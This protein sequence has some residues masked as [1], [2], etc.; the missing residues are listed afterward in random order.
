[1]MKIIKNMVILACLSLSFFTACDSYEREGVT[2]EIYVNKQELTLVVG[3]TD[4]LIVSPSEGGAE[5]E[6]A[7]TDIVTV[8]GNGV[9]TAV[10]PGSTSVMVK[11]GNATFTV[12]VTVLNSNI[13]SDVTL[14]AD[15]LLGNYSVSLIPG[16]TRK[17][18]VSTTPGNANNVAKDD[19][20]W[21]SDNDHV[22]HVYNDGTILGVGE[23]TTAVHYRLGAITKD[24]DVYVSSTS[25]FK[26]PH[27]LS[28]AVPLEL[29]FLD[30]DFGGPEVAWHDADANNRGGSSYRPDNGDSDAGGVDIE[31]STNIGYTANGEWL[32]YTVD[33]QDSGYYGLELCVSGSGGEL[34][35]EIDGENV[36]GTV[37]VISTGG[38]SDYRY[39]TVSTRDIRLM[40]GRHKVK[41]VFDK[42]NFNV[43]SMR[44]TYVDD[45]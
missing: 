38:W 29:S 15:K 20:A 21:W 16:A 43:K 42:A 12:Q 7:A 41:V 36:T 10:S 13:L 32:V 11:K 17:I 5:W 4:T 18:L 14:S 35:Y 25:P 40:K 31:G 44:F 19:Y 24:I 2:N 28:K 37:N 1:M 3:H 9:V 23:G 45:L 8:D 27:I 34:H 30:F 26:G 39:N 22:A 6:S 33:V